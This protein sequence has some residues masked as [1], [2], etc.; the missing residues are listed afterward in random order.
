MTT[1]GGQIMSSAGVSPEIFLSIGRRD[2][3]A[4]E[5]I[6]PPL[7]PGAVSI[8]STAVLHL[9]DGYFTFII[10]G[11]NVLQVQETATLPK[12]IQEHVAISLSMVLEW[13]LYDKAYILGDKTKTF[14]EVIAG[15]SSPDITFQRVGDV[16]EVAWDLTNWSRCGSRF[17]HAVGK[18]EIDYLEF[19]LVLAIATDGLLAASRWRAL[20]CGCL[21]HWEQWLSGYKKE[22]VSFHDSVRKQCLEKDKGIAPS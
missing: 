20:S 1:L 16:V 12:V 10:G 11:L 22:L 14:S 9:T 3:F 5:A 15:E 8:D 19:L 7:R 17:E 18:E 4:L 2:S 21:A 13:I 6:L